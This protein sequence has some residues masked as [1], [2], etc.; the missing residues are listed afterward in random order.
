MTVTSTIEF[1]NIALGK[2]DD[3]IARALVNTG[4]KLIGEI[5]N[6]QVVPFDTG[7]LNG[8]SFFMDDSKAKQ[9]HITLIHS[10]PYARRLYYHPEYNFNTEHHKNARGRWFEDWLPGGD[11]EYD[12]EL[13]FRNMLR[14]E[15]QH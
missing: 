14:E 12:V 10:T 3:A 7:N 13:I 1:N 15:M 5:R 8:E 2:V 6:A 11:K 4:D 9:G